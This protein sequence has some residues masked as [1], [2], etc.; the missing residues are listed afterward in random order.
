MYTALNWACSFKYIFL[1][2]QLYTLTHGS[3]PPIKTVTGDF[4][5]R[6]RPG[7]ATRLDADL[8]QAHGMS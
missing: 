1:I 6:F 7:R 5:K 2:E 8:N 3:P 4:Q